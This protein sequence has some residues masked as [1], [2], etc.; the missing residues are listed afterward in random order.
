MVYEYLKILKNEKVGHIDFA[1]YYYM[2]GVLIKKNA[3]EIPSAY[4]LSC[5][6]NLEIDKLKSEMPAIILDP[7]GYQVLW[8]LN[9]VEVSGHSL[10][11]EMSDI[12]LRTNRV[13]RGGI[14]TYKLSGW[15]AHVLYVY[16]IVTYNIPNGIPP[17]YF[18]GN[19]EVCSTFR[20]MQK[21]YGNLSQKI[22]LI[23]NVYA[24]I[25][26][27]GV[28]DGVQKHDQ[29]GE[30]YVEQILKDL[31]LNEGFWNQY[32]LTFDEAIKILKVLVENHTL[33]NKI[34]AEDSDRS[35]EDRCACIVKKL[36]S[37]VKN[38]SC[39]ELAACY[40]LLG[41]A[42]LIAVDDSLYTTQKYNLA[43]NSYFFLESIFSGAPIERDSE[44]IAL[45]RLG[46]MVK[47]TT[48]K[49]IKNE[50]QSILRKENIDY[51]EF[52]KNLYMIYRLEYGTTYLKPLNSLKHTIL[53]LYKLMNY[54]GKAFGVEKLTNLVITFDSQ[55]SSS[56]FKTAVENGEYLSDMEKLSNKKLSVRSGN[57]MISYAVDINRLFI[58]TV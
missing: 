25:H 27:I 52:C 35:I 55:M 13:V 50:T 48:Y 33:I 22:K 12:F 39:A 8:Y 15:M 17:S 3:K 7:R 32:S 21:V 51:N 41:L 45:L 42:D 37:V 1:S 58:F 53:I 44:Q 38:F 16:Q 30:K 54:V 20:K 29:D 6:A 24:L 10:L 26:D 5:D 9:A 11:D 31:Q 14:N 23:I 49:D 19:D 28:I 46:E 43:T 36:G 18:L 4:P 40:Y 57:L 56:K 2:R 47:E 34:S